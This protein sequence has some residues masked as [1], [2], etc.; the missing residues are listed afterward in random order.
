MDD[1]NAPSPLLTNA[2]ERLSL[3]GRTVL[4]SNFLVPGGLT[5]LLAMTD[6]KLLKVD[7]RQEEGL[8]LVEL[9]F[10]ATH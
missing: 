9:P 4:L 10:R 3:H 5:P 8:L 6:G 7:T 1:P 2:V